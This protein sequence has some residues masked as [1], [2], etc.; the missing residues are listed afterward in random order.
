[1]PPK[2]S[3]YVCNVYPVYNGEMEKHMQVPEEIRLALTLARQT[4]R[5]SGKVATFAKEIEHILERGIKQIEV[6]ELPTVARRA[7]R[8][9]EEQVIY[10]VD[11]DRGHGEA[12]AEHRTSGKS[13]PMRCPKKVYDALARV[14]TGADR[15]L[16]LEEIMAAVGKVLGD[17]PADHQ[18]RVALR[19]W[20]HVDPPLLARNRAR[21][22]PLVNMDFSTSALALWQTL[23]GK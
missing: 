10:V 19:L 21:Y 3:S 1:M 4:A 16:G 12:L 23:I 20:M 6:A 15:P 14:L 13:K 7:D 5:G 2:G 18:V 22:R 9:G 17:R 11:Q 8:S